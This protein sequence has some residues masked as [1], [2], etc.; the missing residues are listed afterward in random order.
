MPT[1][2]TAIA[3][4][5]T[6][7]TIGLAG[8]NSVV[9]DFEDSSET[10]SPDNTQ[11]IPTITGASHIQ[12][13][14]FLF[15]INT[16]IN[17]PESESRRRDL[18]I[19][20]YDNQNSQLDKKTIT[21]VLPPESEAPYPIRIPGDGYNPKEVTSDKIEAALSEEDATPDEDDYRRISSNS[22][23]E[24]TDFLTLGLPL[25]TDENGDKNIDNIK[26]SAG[27]P[28][29]YTLK[30]GEVN[31]TFVTEGTATVINGSEGDT[32]QYRDYENTTPILEN[33]DDTIVVKFQLSE[34]RALPQWGE[35]QK[36]M[37]VAHHE[38]HGSS[39]KLIQTQK[40]R[41]DTNLAL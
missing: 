13:E 22:L 30:M 23:T 38:D 34:I 24:K 1:R 37:I 33:T 5:A 6:G 15:S 12:L 20:L 7:G 14:E 35:S 8:C 17:N 4:I 16:S 10:S 9:S 39:F 32:V 27:I 25:G 28:Y 2:R 3:T 21:T 26:F 36:G 19:R 18:H 11:N 40:I 31:F 29:N 41:K